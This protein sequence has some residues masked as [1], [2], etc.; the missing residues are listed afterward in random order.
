MNFE[1]F[2]NYIEERYKQKIDGLEKKKEKLEETYDNLLDEYKKLKPP[3]IT[4]KHPIF[5]AVGGIGMALFTLALTY[6]L[7]KLFLHIP[8]GLFVIPGSIIGSLSA[9]TGVEIY[10]KYNH[11]KG[12]DNDRYLD[13][14]EEKQTL[15]EELNELLSLRKEC[16][17]QIENVKKE[18]L[19]SNDIPLAKE[20]YEYLIPP[21]MKKKRIYLNE[22]LLD[23]L[24]KDT[25]L[26]III[27]KYY[28]GELE[29]YI[30]SSYYERYREKQKLDLKRKIELAK[31]KRNVENKTSETFQ[32]SE[33]TPI[34][35]E[36]S[37]QLDKVI[38]TNKQCEI[39]QG[40]YQ[41]RRRIEK[42]SY[43]YPLADIDEN[44]T[45]SCHR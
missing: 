36:P 2:L 20:C 18:P 23:S 35:L 10:K 43:D 44:D 14:Q 3:L 8:N 26:A 17:W 31:E 4:K 41:R 33:E 27:Y 29:K 34:L 6:I 12:Q 24:L 15:K 11:E 19:N 45:K 37:P 9:L 40:P 30:K 1:E 22:T 38:T 21:E 28:H 39:P 5:Y 13:Y 32:Q 7:T 42:Y 16:N 25:S